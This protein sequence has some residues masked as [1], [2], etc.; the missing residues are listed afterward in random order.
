MDQLGM[1]R[2]AGAIDLLLILPSADIPGS[3][4]ERTAAA[5]IDSGG[6]D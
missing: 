5:T 3:S 4:A 2:H 1:A 6:S